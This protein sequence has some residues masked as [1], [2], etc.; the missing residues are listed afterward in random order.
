MFIERTNKKGGLAPPFLVSNWGFL[1][2][3]AMH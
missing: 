3:L 2:D 1:Y